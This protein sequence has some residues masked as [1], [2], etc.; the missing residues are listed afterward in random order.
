MECG[1][2]A[3]PGCFDSGF[4]GA[5]DVLRCADAIR[6]GVRPDVP[7][8]RTTIL[9]LGMD[10][11][12]TAGGLTVPVDERLEVAELDRFDVLVV[13]SVFALDPPR[14]REV[15]RLP[16]IENLTDFLRER[17]GPTPLRRG[18]PRPGSFL[19]AEAGLLDGRQATTTWW[20]AE[21]FRRRYPHVDLDMQ[22]MVVWSGPVT[23]AGA[24]FAH[25]DLVLSLLL[26]I[27]PELARRTAE[28]LLVDARPSLSADGVAGYLDQDDSLV[29][30]FETWILDHLETPFTIADAATAI[31]TTRK[32]LERHTREW[33]GVSPYGL[34]QRL[35]IERALHLQR[36]SAL[37]MDQ[38]ARRVGYRNAST[39]RGLLR[40]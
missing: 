15:L 7:P 37:S 22:R 32:T 23:T 20:L 28:M 36:I 4:T 34:V 31:G 14:L 27:S 26:R 24:A 40:H 10:S 11:V 21:E 2:V 38:I 19:L 6:S 25:V 33:A 29:T 9:A 1:I 8:L 17:G 16:E 3:V 5:L 35:R 13:P 18:P 12:T 30:A 39:L